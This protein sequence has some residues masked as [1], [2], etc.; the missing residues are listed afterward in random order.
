MKSFTIEVVASSVRSCINAQQGGA[1]RIELCSA[2][3]TAGVTPSNGLLMAVKKNIALPVYV[4]IRPREGDFCYDAREVDTMKLEIECLQ[5]AGSDGFVFGMLQKNGEVNHAL[6]AELV[7]FCKPY[8]VTFHRA[9]DCT[10]NM[11]EALEAI[12][13]TGCMRVLTSGGKASGPEGVENIIQLAE[14]S[15]GRISIMPGGG[16]SPATFPSM[17]HKSIIDYHLSGRLAV[18]SPIPFKL[19]DMNW[20]ETDEASIRD[21][22]KEAEIF[23]A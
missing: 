5:K 4:M 17:L 12:I 21:V 20:T 11:S 15:S 3:A 2:L 10:P 19:F 14:Q 18:A 23:F 22:V 1:S 7:A 6:T 16:I 9:I 13:D 8:P